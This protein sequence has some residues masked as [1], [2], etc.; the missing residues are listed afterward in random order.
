MT[1]RGPLSTAQIEAAWESA[2]KYRELGRIASGQI[3]VDILAL[4]MEAE[5][6][7]RRASGAAGLF[8][9]GAPRPQSRSFQGRPDAHG[10]LVH[11]QECGHPECG[12]RDQEIRRMARA[13]NAGAGLKRGT[14]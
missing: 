6:Y 12:A 1:A 3:S 9:C 5:E 13:M 10:A 2:R 14:R 4:A 7:V 8:P 11:Y